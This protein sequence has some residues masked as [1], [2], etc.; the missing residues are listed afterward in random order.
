MRKLTLALISI[1]ALTSAASADSKKD[2][3]E[4]AKEQPTQVK[5]HVE[6]INGKRTVVVDT[7]V[8]ICGHPP[9]PSVAYVLTP[10]NIDYTWEALEQ[11]FLPRIL[12]SVKKAPL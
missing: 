6:V 4:K 8:L 3:C 7:D 5:S 11:G 1:A 9:K 12:S 10:K 2:E